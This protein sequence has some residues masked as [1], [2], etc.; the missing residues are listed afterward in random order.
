MKIPYQKEMNY[1]LMFEEPIKISLNYNE[2]QKEA[3]KDL[4]N[5]YSHLT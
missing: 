3:F 5:D 1:T 2:T 4:S